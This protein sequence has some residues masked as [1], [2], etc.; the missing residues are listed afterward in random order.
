MTT[1]VYS[2]QDP[3]RLVSSVRVCMS[4]GHATLT[5]WNRGGNCGDLMVRQEDATLMTAR[6]MGIGIESLPTPDVYP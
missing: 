5:V 3:Q 4:G 1:Y 6:L 2:W